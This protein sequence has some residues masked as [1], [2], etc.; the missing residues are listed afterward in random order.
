MNEPAP[1][2]A[3]HNSE[4]IGYTAAHLARRTAISAQAIR[5]QLAGIKPDGMKIV[6][7]QKAAAWSW[8]LFPDCL[9]RRIEKLSREGSYR[10]P[11]YFL[12]DDKEQWKPKLALSKVANKD[13]ERAKKLC[14]ALL[15][16]LKR[17]HDGLPA[18]RFEFLGLQDYAKAFGHSVSA[19]HF[20]ELLQRTC[21]RDAGAEQWSRI[22]L[23]LSDKPKS[24]KSPQPN[25]SAAVEFES[26][27]NV[28]NSFSDPMNL[29]SANREAAWKAALHK[30]DRLVADGE[31]PAR[32]ARRLRAFLHG[33]IP[34]LAQS[35]NAL[36]MA[37][38]RRLQREQQNPRDPNS[39]RDGRK[40]NGQSPEIPAEDIERLLHSAAFKNGGRLNDAW[41]EEYLLLSEQARKGGS[42]F[43]P[44]KRIRDLVN[45]EQINA[46]FTRHQGKLAAKRLC[47]TVDCNSDSLPSMARWVVDDVTLP[48]QLT[49]TENGPLFQ[50]QAVAVMD[51]ASRMFVGLAISDDKGPTAELT[52]EA[53]REAFKKFGVPQELRVE[54]GFVFGKSL[55]IN[56]KE[57]EQGRTVVAGLAHYGC[58]VRHFG[59]MNPTGK[60]ELEKAFDLIQ[61]RLER[62]PGYT[63]RLQMLDAP[64]EFK[65]EQ[66]LIESGKAPAKEFRLT[67]E[68]GVKQIE[69]IFHDY[70]RTAQHGHLDGKSPDVAHD[71]MR[72]LNNPPILFPP[73]LWW[74]LANARYLVSVKTSGIKFRHYGRII[75]VRGAE[76]AQRIGEQLWALVDRR[77]DSLVT[78]LDLNF[79]NPFT[80]ETCQQPHKAERLT[81]TCS[82]VLASERAKIAEHVRTL[83]AEYK[84]LLDKF[85]NPRRDLLAAI[86]QSP[87]TTATPARIAV[88]D[89]QEM[90]SAQQMESQRGEFRERRSKGER[91]KQ[92]ARRLAQK[93]G[94]VPPSHAIERPNSAE[95]MSVLDTFLE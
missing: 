29:T 59:K 91:E 22:E 3:N 51:S 78:F 43:R 73:E 66:R 53:V 58:E 31:S 69:K 38:A 63:G 87:D 90:E 40:D 67:F 33:R 2:S 82:G 62:Y 94:I 50:P 21:Q 1:G 89:P 84:Q 61:R 47:G 23:Y 74:L 37:F 32:A 70:N 68:E 16:S 6:G 92:R 36:R 20:R 49:K 44:H 81:A 15:P 65:R 80:M 10:D 83:D 34:S 76:L 26:M 77:D 27:E 5:Q 11:R 55:N 88:I 48:I 46:L 35:K 72:D 4:S 17:L 93:T 24:K 12:A 14:D 86:R 18:D 13:V 30:Y 7:G 19:R 71:Q 25:P 52:C 28:I 95:D 60:A 54:N 75:K 57:D 79:Q 8:L 41:R 42:V 56:G 9:K 85:G 45:R 64:E 39:Q